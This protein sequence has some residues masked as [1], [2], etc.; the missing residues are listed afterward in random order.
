MQVPTISSDIP[1]VR[2]R[3]KL[4][5]I[6]PED[7]NL[8]LFNPN[9]EK[10]L[11]RYIKEVYQH[12]SETYIKQKDTVYDKLFEYNWQDVSNQYIELF[13]EMVGSS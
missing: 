12:P 8:Y 2:E 6:N 4:I 11:I 13:Q 3:L 9:N 1:V 10:Q 5:N 7:S